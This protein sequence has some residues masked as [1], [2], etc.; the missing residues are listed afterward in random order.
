M[1]RLAVRG[2]LLLIPT[3]LPFFF[4]LCKPYPDAG[5]DGGASADLRSSEGKKS[6]VT[7]KLCRH[8]DIGTTSWKF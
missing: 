1:S 7:V 2:I 8:Q 5:G 6:Q 4:L 3:V